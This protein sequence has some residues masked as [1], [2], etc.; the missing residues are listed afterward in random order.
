MARLQRFLLVAAAS[1]LLLT[2]AR[3]EEN[4]APGPACTGL[5]S[6]TGAD[7][8]AWAQGTR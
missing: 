7:T 2:A 5:N 4:P 3:G 6:P 8:M 1:A